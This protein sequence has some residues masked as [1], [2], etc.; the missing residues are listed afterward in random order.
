[1]TS[2]MWRRM[3]ERNDVEDGWRLRVDD[4]RGGQTSSL[5]ALLGWVMRQSCA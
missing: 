5:Q 3:T 1:M 2:Q 4:L